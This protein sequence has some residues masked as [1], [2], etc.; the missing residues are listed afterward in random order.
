MSERAIE[1]KGD[2]TE[3]WKDFCAGLGLQLSLDTTGK[4]PINERW[5]VN[6]SPVSGGSADQLRV[7]Q[8]GGM[9]RQQ[10]GPGGFL[11]END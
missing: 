1:Q 3:T 7:H 4:A 9:E 11:Q 2:R 6:I 8:V 5:Q 10:T